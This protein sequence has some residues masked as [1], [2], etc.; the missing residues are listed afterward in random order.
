MEAA[1]RLLVLPRRTAEKRL[2]A[3]SAGL[4]KPACRQKERDEAMDH[5]SMFD[6]EGLLYVGAV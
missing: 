1:W 3:V 5:W 6:K 4:A 2:A